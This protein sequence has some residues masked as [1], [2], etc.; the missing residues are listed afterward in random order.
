MVNNLVGEIRRSAVLMT[1][2]PGAVVDMRSESAPISG[3]SAGLEEWDS[4]APLVGNL[5]HQRIIERRLCKKLNKRFFRLPPVVGDDD[6][7][8]DGTPDPAA[9][10][11]SRFPRWLQ[12]PKCNRIRPAS[13]WHNDPGRPY[14]Y[15]KACTDREPGQAKVFAVPVRFVAACVRG[16]LDDFPWHFWVRH[17]HGCEE[18][19]ALTFTSDAPGLAGLVVTCQKCGAHRSMD[20]AFSGKALAG[21]TCSGRRP[22]LRT[23]DAGCDSSGDTATFRVLQRGASNL[24]Y[25]I[26]ESALDIPPWTKR[27]ESLL[28]DYWEEL[29]AFDDVDHRAGWINRLPAL[30]AILDREGL[31]AEAVSR[32]FERMQR[33]LEELDPQDLRT[34]EYR[35]F[36]AGG[37]HTDRDFETYPTVVPERLSGLLHGIGRV[38]RLREVRVVRSFTRISPPAGSDNDSRE[39]PLSVQPLE[40]LPA[41]EIRGEGIF[42]DLATDAL[43]E[44]ERS[45]VVVEHCRPL[46]AAW[47]IEWHHRNDNREMPFELT[48]RRLLVHT[49]AHAVMRQL[50]LEC[51]YS[52]ASLRERL[53]VADGPNGM[54]G[55]LI[56]T[57]TA[58]SDGTLGGLQGRARHDLI[59]ATVVGSIQASAWCSSDPL[60]IVGEMAAPDS[61]SGA[62]CHSCTMVPE[63]S[64]E[65][66]NRFLDR[67]LLVGTESNSDLGLFRRLLGASN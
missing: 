3:L 38:A 58:D 41:L 31:T 16:H 11:M 6:H 32:E 27:L 30:K 19:D 4:S 59:E 36:S 56:F 55:V 63:T 10:V 1:Y 67:A 24:Y 53:Y 34:D 48:P 50:T 57:G 15:C 33:Q 21:L 7:L 22:W 49:F 29:E 54:A 47:E 37:E 23:D 40:W 42:L 51:G 64:C 66:N 45:P 9:L 60:C 8:R 18:K 20:G 61:M 43:E 13:K 46:A 35:V 44:W 2:A 17:R 26:V 25:P 65:L 14:R 12:C 28:G 62:S 39:A 5:A 52:S